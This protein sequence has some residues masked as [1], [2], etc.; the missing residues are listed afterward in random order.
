MNHD[1]LRR[2]ADAEREMSGT[3]PMPAQQGEVAGE[4][5]G[6]HKPVYY[7]PGSIGE[8]D[9][10][11]EC[12]VGGAYLA[13]PST[14]EP[15]PDTVAD[16]RAEVARLNRQLGLANAAIL[17]L[18]DSLWIVG[19]NPSK[20]AAAAVDNYRASAVT[21][22]APM[23]ADTA[24]TARVAE[25]EL[26]LN[27]ALGAVGDFPGTQASGRYNWRTILAEKAGLVYNGER[28]VTKARRGPEREGL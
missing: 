16:L 22:A 28:Y 24:L 21:E 9:T 7:R 27:W 4:C 8:Y 19:A 12:R 3:R 11:C 25:L 14:A 23:P 13:A 17:G 10:E 18:E 26:A 2:A 6:C 1:E 20:F 5:A 15:Q